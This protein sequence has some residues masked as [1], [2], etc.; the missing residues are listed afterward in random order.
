[1]MANSKDNEKLKKLG[2]SSLLDLALLLPKSYDNTFINQTPA[3]NQINTIHVKVLR[4]NLSRVLSLKFWC[5][6]WEEEINGVIFHPMA[7]H[8][9]LFRVGESLHVRGKIEWQA[10]K[11]SIIQ[12]Q[13][14]TQI[15][16][17]IPKYKSSLQNRSIS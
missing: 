9:G 8:R 17:I 14:I 2:V 12:P 4:S 15:N 1:M 7:Y 10:G 5:E 13:I 16:T 3:L 6:T 11:L